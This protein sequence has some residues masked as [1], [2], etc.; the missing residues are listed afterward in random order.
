MGAESFS[1]GTSGDAGNQVRNTLGLLPVIALSA[2]LTGPAFAQSTAPAAPGGTIDVGEVTV[3]GDGDGSATANANDDSTR[4]GRLPGTV[5]DTPQVVNVIPQ[6]VI[7]QQAA[8]TLNDVLRNV[9][10][11]TLVIGEGGGGFNGSNFRIRG[12]SAQTDLYVD[13]LRDFGTYTRDSFNMESVQVFKGPTSETFGMG[14]TGGAVNTQ[15]KTAKLENFI[16]VT[17]GGGSGP[18]GRGTFDLNR[19]INDTT[20][21]RVNGMVHGGQVPDRDHVD[22]DRWGVAATVGFGIGTDLE[23]NL[24]FFHQKDNRTADYGI[25]VFA[26]GTYGTG[27]NQR[28]I[29]VGMPATEFG[30]DRSNFYGLEN[31]A[32]DS[33][34]DMLTGRLKYEA[35]DWL[36]IYN[37]TRVSYYDRFFTPQAV[38]CAAAT[39]IT[40]YFNGLPA[41]V[42][43]GGPPP[44]SQDGWAAQ[45]VTT[46][47]AKFETGR[48]RHEFVTGLDMHTQRNTRYGWRYTPTTTRPTTDLVDPDWSTTLDYEKNGGVTKSEARNIG[49]FASERLWLTEQLSV[50]GGVRWDWYSVDTRLTPAQGATPPADPSPSSRSTL[51]N[52]KA[53]VIWEPTRDQT[54][55]V[56]WARSATPQGLAVSTAT[57]TP[58]GNDA[59]DPEENENFE[60]GG[61]I[62]LLDGRLGL[63]GAIF[64]TNKN[65]ALIDNGDGSV[66]STGEQQRIRGVEIGVSGQVTDVVTLTAG[67]TYLDTEITKAY[68]NRTAPLTGQELNP[69]VIG[70]EVSFTPKHSASVWATY[71]ASRHIEDSVGG[72]LLVGT[73]V[74]Y[75]SKVWLNSQNT[76]IAPENISWDAL[77]SYERDNYRLALNVYNITDRLNYDQVFANRIIPSSGRSFFLTA[78]AKF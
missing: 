51:F 76:S 70:N 40:P 47:V 77:V 46:A 61:K 21:F 16:D 8:T 11:V 12:Q 64:Q 29:D 48:F 22:A 3:E 19:M 30:I 44:Y 35:N 78:G 34:V 28:V 13:G 25:P 5:Q 57:G 53:A 56:S 31:D 42:T 23:Y 68:R 36:T 59:L 7:R 37:D 43:R 4:I 60:V 73:G 9:P 10:G 24:S 50:S 71:D 18:Q 65:N 27:A 26:A 62:N 1:S 52:P 41:T 39:C 45:N 32:D 72:K 66:T 67:Y 63:S 75:R 54:Y 58:A 2:A 74:T 55:Y 69:D 38:S 6:E 33:Q 15:S 49:V 20:A 17:A 14:T